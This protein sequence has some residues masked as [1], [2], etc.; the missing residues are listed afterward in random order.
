M[1]RVTLSVWIDALTPKQLLLAYAI[2]TSLKRENISYVITSR[3][4]EYVDAITRR[5]GLDTVSVGSYGKNLAEKLTADLRRGLELL[6]IRDVVDS[7]VLI[8]YPSPS[9]VRTAFGLA[10]KI[11]I[12]T[13][14]PHALHAHRLTVPLADYLVYSSFI[15]RREMERY[16]LGEFTKVAR[17]EG[18]DEVSWVKRLSPD[19]NAFRE[20]G[21]DEG[22]ILARPPERYAAYYREY[23]QGVDFVK[24]VE[25][26]AELRPVV[27]IPRYDEDYLMYKGLNNVT[28]IK[29]MLAL[30]L[31][32]KAGLVVTG[33][34]T[35][36]REAAL[37]GKP[38]IYTFATEVSVNR[39]L[40]L[41]GFPIYHAPGLEEAVKLAH[42]LLESGGMEDDAEKMLGRL[43]D[44]V[45]LLIDIVKEIL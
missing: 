25:K 17:F 15:E 22:Y 38:S 34:G 11:V 10:K 30:D 8:S 21:L 42:S 23:G 35:M 18:V 24:L 40:R 9:A 32:V 12:I 4:G 19:P 16:L 20:H 7:S 41:M 1:V 45:D 33:G 14:T 26:L 13:D 2:A 28:L 29:P 27:V 6:E 44:P 36:A 5:L 3:K 43:E 31:M 39:R 37:I